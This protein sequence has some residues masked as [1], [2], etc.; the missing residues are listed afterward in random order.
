MQDQ[1]L[2]NPGKASILEIDFHMKAV[3]YGSQQQ[4]VPV[5]QTFVE[6][7]F[8]KNEKGMFFTVVFYHPALYATLYSTFQACFQ[9]LLAFMCQFFC[10]F[11]L[12]QGLID[13]PL[14]TLSNQ[15]IASSQ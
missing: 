15:R 3:F 4:E 10:M 8:Q 6:T 12:H 1:K 9:S 14:I 2:V 5:R 13:V 11:K 7:S